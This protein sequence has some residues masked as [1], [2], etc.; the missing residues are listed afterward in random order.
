MPCWRRCPPRRSTSA[1]A[2]PSAQTLEQVVQGYGG[3][4]RG[5]GGVTAANTA[6]AGSRTA[7]VAPGPDYSTQIELRV[8]FDPA[9]QKASFHRLYRLRSNDAVAETARVL[10]TAY[11]IEPLGDALILSFD[12]LPEGFEQDHGDARH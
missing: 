4:Y 9:T 12:A 5:S 1:P 10:E 11:R 3:D 8:A 7:A 6:F 2:P